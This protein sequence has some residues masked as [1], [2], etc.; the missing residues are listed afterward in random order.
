MRGGYS[1][2]PVD[3]TKRVAE[4]LLVMSGLLLLLASESLGFQNQPNQN[5]IAP[6][7]LQ[8]LYGNN[9]KPGQFGSGKGAG[10]RSI[11]VTGL[12]KNA[13]SEK[14]DPS[15]GLYDYID[16]MKELNK[17][18]S[19]KRIEIQVGDQLY[20]FKN[21]YRDSADTLQFQLAERMYDDIRECDT[22]ICNIAENTGFKATNIKKVKDH[23]FYNKH[24]LDRYA[25]FDPYGLDPIKYKCFDGN[26][27]QAL[28][29]KRLETGTFNQNDL[30]WVKHE[31]AERHHELKYDSGYAEAHERAQSL[32]DGS[33]WKYDD[34]LWKK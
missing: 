25:E 3:V 5:G 9:Y 11:T 4:G 17:Q 27:E 33:P 22:D 13:A 18:S 21:P 34:S 26:L 12:T 15:P 32:Y 20:R 7:H 24:Y 19:K 6:P 31:Y 28:A 29:W 14:K 16:I 30:T 10:P 2:D 1:L 23:L 8:W